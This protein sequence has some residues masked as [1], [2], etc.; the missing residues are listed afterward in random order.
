MIVIGI[1]PL[2]LS[3]VVV[4]MYVFTLSYLSLLPIKINEVIFVLICPPTYLSIYRMHI[5]NIES[6][7][8]SM[9]SIKFL[10]M[11]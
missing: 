9:L 4:Y 2:L 6:T 3:L 8:V 7:I 11:R 10:R 5:Q 1:I